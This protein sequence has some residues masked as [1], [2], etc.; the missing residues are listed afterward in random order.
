MTTIELSINSVVS[1]A[2]GA[3][4]GY[5]VFKALG[6]KNGLRIGLPKI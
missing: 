2:A 5:G 1:I 4:S 6:K 3:A